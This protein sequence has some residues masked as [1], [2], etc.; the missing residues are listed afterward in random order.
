MIFDIS[1]MNDVK[2]IFIPSHNCFVDTRIQGLYRG[3]EGGGRTV[4]SFESLM[5]FAFRNGWKGK[6]KGIDSMT[7]CHCE[8]FLQYLKIKLL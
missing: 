2:H 6:E 4:Y 7:E 1:G 3:V 5:E 8:V